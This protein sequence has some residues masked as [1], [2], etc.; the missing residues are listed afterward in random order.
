MHERI[1]RRQEKSKA[2]MEQSLEDTAQQIMRRHGVRLPGKADEGLGLDD[3]DDD[4]SLEPGAGGGGGGGS[5]GAAAAARRG[6]GGAGAGAGRGGYDDDDMGDDGVGVVDPEVG[7]GRC[8][9]LL[10]CRLMLMVV[11]VCRRRCCGGSTYRGCNCCRRCLP[12]HS[13]WW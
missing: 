6:G 5:G 10:L 7:V 1:Q 13:C 8:V 4:F 9:S 3:D 2:F 12:P 11:L